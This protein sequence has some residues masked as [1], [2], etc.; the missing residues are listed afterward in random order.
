M[1]PERKNSTPMAT[2]IHVTVLSGY[3]MSSI[4]TAMAQM[5]RKNELCNIF[6]MGLNSIFAAKIQKK[7][8]ITQIIAD[9]F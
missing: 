6:I 3:L 5:A 9:Y 2:V 8:Q 4:P 7:P 1:M